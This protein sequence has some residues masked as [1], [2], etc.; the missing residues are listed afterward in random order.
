MRPRKPRASTESLFAYG[1]DHGSPMLQGFM[2]H[3]SYS[4]DSL[5]ASYRGLYSGVLK[6]LL[7]GMLGV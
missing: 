7:R 3:M 2:E 4:L 5:E 6:G 1:R